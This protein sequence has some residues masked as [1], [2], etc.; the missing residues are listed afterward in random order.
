MIWPPVKAW[1]SKRYIENQAH[2]VAIDYGGALKN[3][4]VVLMSVL[5]ASVVVKVAWS[6]LIA[7]F[8]WES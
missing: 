5:D 8:Y 4:W 7:S 3:R 6:E 1:P 2:F